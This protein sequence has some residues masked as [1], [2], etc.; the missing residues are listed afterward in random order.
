M[1]DPK[2]KQYECGFTQ[3]TTMNSLF[4]YW[5]A[6]T[7]SNWEDIFDLSTFR[8]Y[9]KSGRENDVVAGYWNYT[10]AKLEEKKLDYFLRYKLAP[11]LENVVTKNS[12]GS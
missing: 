10:M 7:R 1:A 3:K 4:P 6:E 2:M 12:S 5:I 11:S 8:E 9:A